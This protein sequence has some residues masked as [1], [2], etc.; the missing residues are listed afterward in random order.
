MPLPA[1]STFLSILNYSFQRNNIQIF[2]FLKKKRGILFFVPSP[3]SS[4]YPP[5][6][7][8]SNP[9]Y[10]AFHGKRCLWSL[11]LVPCLSVSPQ[12]TSLKPCLLL[13]APENVL[14]VVMMAS[15]CQIQRWVLCLLPMLINTTRSQQPRLPPWSS[16]LS[17]Q[18][19]AFSRPSFY[20][21]DH[22][23][24][25]F[26]W[27]FLLLGWTCKGW[28]IPVLAADALLSLFTSSVLIG[29]IFCPCHLETA[30]WVCDLQ[31]H[32]TANGLLWSSW[33]PW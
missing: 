32:T 14:A 2:S 7:H 29:A 4:S 16:S 10:S 25:Y 8:A 24:Q 6:T 13:Q 3:F 23:A 1:S 17:L 11:C 15:T 22:L 31:A 12:I 20:G 28:L 21:R 30:S 26:S 5:I 9:L 27:L 19:A 18:D 33:N